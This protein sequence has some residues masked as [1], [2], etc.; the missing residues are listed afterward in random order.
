VNDRLEHSGMHWSIKG[1][2]ALLALRSIQLNSLSVDY[3]QFHQEKEGKRLHG[4]AWS[5]HQQDDQQEF[6]T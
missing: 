2:N 6:V 4:D 5:W 3:W 1:A